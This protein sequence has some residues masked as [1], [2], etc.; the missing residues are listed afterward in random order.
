MK[1]LVIMWSMYIGGTTKSLVPFLKHLHKKGMEVELYLID[2]SESSLSYVPEEIKIAEIPELDEILCMPSNAREKIRWMMERRILHIAL[3]QKVLTLFPKKDR[4]EHRKAV[5]RLYQE[6]DLATCKNSKKIVDLSKRYDAVLSWCEF[7][8]DYA[9]ANNIICNKKYGWIHPDYA[10]GGFN[11]EIDKKALNGLTGLVA[12]SKSGYQSMLQAFP[13]WKDH[14]YAV[15]NV[16]D[17]ENL[18]ALAKESQTEIPCDNTFKIVT[19]ARIHNISKAF[20]R[21]VRVAAKLKE[22]GCE[23]CWYIVGDGEDKV[24][25]NEQIVENNLQDNMKLLGAKDNPYPYMA[26]GN[27]F[28]LQSYY[29]GKPLVVDEALVVGTPVLVTDYVSAKEQVSEK[30]GIVVK[31]HEDA[32]T[33]TLERIIRNP[34]IAEE[35]KLNL[36]TYDLNYLTECPAFFEMIN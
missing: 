4:E 24:S 21:A 28:V 35:W 19:V 31:N 11:P 7:L 1:I 27:L 8:P 23:F 33:D 12:V 6:R 9:V 16:M 26:A 5:M 30:V 20:D 3:K 32:I 22:R 34:Q 36:Q 17:V 29:E 15:P 14:I 25:V 10:T 13:E 18:R 2:R